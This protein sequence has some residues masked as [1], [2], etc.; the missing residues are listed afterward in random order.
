MQRYV[1]KEL[2][3]F[4]GRKLRE[5]TDKEQRL[6]GQYKIL[7]KIICDGCISSP[8]H[9]TK[10]LPEG[11]KY[12][13][14]YPPKQING[15]QKFS[16][17]KMITPNPVCFCDIPLGDLGIHIN[18]Y[19][20]FGLSF[21]KS[22]LIERG[23]N[24]VLYV[25]KDSAIC[26]KKFLKD[27]QLDSTRIEYLDEM[28]YLFGEICFPLLEFTRTGNRVIG[29]PLKECH[30]IA[31]FVLDLLCYIKLFDASKTDDDEENF[32]MEREWRT[33]YNVYFEIKDICRIILPNEF[34]KQFREDFPEYVGQITFS[35]EY[36]ST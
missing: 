13:Q 16:S 27:K 2:T 18:K 14:E 11:M 15:K 10:R 25:E 29:P 28:A 22:F 30:T 8:P 36:S 35:E 33:P 12:P 23:A 19:S 26:Y 5:I 34:S 24:P 6:D 4:V 3:H 17:G 32:Y 7:R 20:P 21:K 1:S 9:L 31:E